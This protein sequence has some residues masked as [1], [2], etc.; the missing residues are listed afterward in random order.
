MSNYDLHF[1]SS[2]FYLAE[3]YNISALKN[4]IIVTICKKEICDENVLDVAILAEKCIVLEEFSD[5]LYDRVAMFLMKKFD[6]KATNVFNFFSLTEATQANGLVLMK[7]MARMHNMTSL[8]CENCKASPCIDGVGI[9]RDN[10]AA[11]ARVVSRVNG[12]QDVYKLLRVLD[13]NKF[14][15][16][17]KDGVL[18]AVWSL[19]PEFYAYKCT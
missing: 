8:A 14:S 6:G 3:K 17:N 9:T 15:A 11:G 18:R 7:L 5:N 1:L 12:G 2:L 13:N 4:E 19:N 10:F 16:V